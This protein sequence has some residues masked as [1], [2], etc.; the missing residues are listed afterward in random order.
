MA[1]LIQAIFAARSMTTWLSPEGPDGGVD[2]LVGS[3]P[4]GMDAPRI[5]VQVKSSSSAVEAGVVRELQGVVGRLKADQGLLVAWG[6][7][8]HA[9]DRE[10]R[11]QFFHVRVWKADDVLRELTAVYDKLPGDIQADLPLKRIWSLA[12]GEEAE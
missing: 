11:Q 5:C 6:G 4:L 9:A 10:I 1:Y 12:D 8:T 3:G 2:V 7:L